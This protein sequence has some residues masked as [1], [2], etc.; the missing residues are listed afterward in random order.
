M[1]E[2]RQALLDLMSSGDRK[3]FLQAMGAADLADLEWLLD[4]VDSVVDDRHANSLSEVDHYTTTAQHHLWRMLILQAI[5]TK[6]IENLTPSE[7]RRYMRKKVDYPLWVL[8]GVVGILVIV[9]SMV[10]SYLT[11]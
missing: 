4:V 9:V 10:Y 5:E 11:R 2:K 8:M 6:E 1:N 3:D 7:M